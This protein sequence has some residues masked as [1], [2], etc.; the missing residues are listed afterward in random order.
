MASRSKPRRG[1]NAS[2]FQ[3]G[4]QLTVSRSGK[5]AARRGDPND[6]LRVWASYDAKDKTLCPGQGKIQANARR[7][8][9]THAG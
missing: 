1:N 5:R 4:G 9:K 7:I 6:Q 8:G 3:G 2:G